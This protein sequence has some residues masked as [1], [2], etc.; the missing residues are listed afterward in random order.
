MLTALIALSTEI[1]LTLDRFMLGKG[2]WDHVL[3]LS[4]LFL[5]GLLE[6]L[7]VYNVRH[8]RSFNDSVLRS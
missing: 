3:I 6:V 2:N 4:S 1:G 8:I 5:S 7:H